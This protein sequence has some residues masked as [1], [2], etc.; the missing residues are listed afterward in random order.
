MLGYGSRSAVGWKMF[1]REIEFMLGADRRRRQ[2]SL[3]KR[4][5]P[6]GFEI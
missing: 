1:D 4:R 3:K 2:A 5:Q 6:I